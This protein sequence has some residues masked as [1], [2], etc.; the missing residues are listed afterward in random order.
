MPYLVDSDWMIDYLGGS[1]EALHLL[2]SLAEE[3]IAISILTYLEI[4]QGVLRS[5]NQEEV[6]EKLLAFLNSVPIIPL[7]PAVARPCARLRESLQVQ[8]KRV[9]QRAI[10]LIIAATALEHNLVLVT[11]NTQDYANIPGLQIYT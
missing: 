3:G 6:E 7:S 11:R 1:L 8:G 2:E 9:N 4:Y 10:D 5:P